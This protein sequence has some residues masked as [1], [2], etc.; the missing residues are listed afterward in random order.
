MVGVS[1]QFHFA[2]YVAFRGGGVGI[3]GLIV[4]IS[5]A[6]TVLF[7]LQMGRWVDRFKCRRVFIGSSAVVV[8]GTLLY[9][10]TDNLWLIGILRLVTVTA[11][12]TFTTAVAVYAA[13]IA[14]PERRAESLGSVGV[15]GFMGMAVGPLLGDAIFTAG[16]DELRFYWYFFGTSAAVWAMA[17]LLAG[18]VGSVPTEEPQPEQPPVSS[19]R[20]IKAHWPG[21][22]L[23]MGLVFGMISAFN[24][25]FLERLAQ[26]RGFE[27]ISFFFLAYSPT[28]IVIRVVFRRL[29]QI[30]GRRRLLMTG[31]FLMAG[32][33]LTVIPVDT[34]V[35]L[36]VPGVIMGAGH[37]MVFPSLV[38]LCAGKLPAAN[39][40][41]GT[42]LAL[43]SIDL[44][45]VVSFVG[46]GQL[47]AWQGFTV[48]LV[49][50]SLIC[51][52][53][54]TLFARS[55]GGVRKSDRLAL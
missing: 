18:I 44:G 13:L 23:A 2:Q 55:L 22:V 10:Q 29:P 21:M 31:V 11:Q 30:V 36:I 26:Q 5:M 15:A 25:G 4:G 24:S 8:V 27:E 19:L 47:I 32:G 39:R 28:G 49:A 17:G 1:L 33:L 38:D 52:V 43:G 41:V 48:M 45:T 35:G 46:F 7:R 16:T 40:G 20:T 3:F 14:P 54:A 37:A 9:A 50:L 53:T 51:A 6:G 42:A 12:Y 34:A